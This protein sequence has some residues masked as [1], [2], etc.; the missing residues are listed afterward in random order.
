MVRDHD[1]EYTEILRLKPGETIMANS[2]AVNVGHTVSMSLLYL[3]QNGNP[4]LTQPVADATP[5]PAWTDDTPAV[6]TLTANGATA[7]E[8]AVTP[9]TDNV[10][11][12]VSVGGVAYKA[13]LAIVVSAAPQVLTSAEIVASVA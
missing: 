7:S 12:A 10:S 13:S 11:V 4:M 5:A 9:G 6:G 1:R 3:D 8:L 2:V